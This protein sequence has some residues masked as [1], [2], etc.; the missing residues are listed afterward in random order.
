M[1][2]ELTKKIGDSVIQGE[3]LAKVHYNEE[4]RLDQASKILKDSFRIGETRDEVPNLIQEVF[5]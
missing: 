3:P 4:S 1:G 2:L 5:E